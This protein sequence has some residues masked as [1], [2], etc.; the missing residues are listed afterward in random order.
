MPEPYRDLAPGI[1]RQRLLLEGY[2]GVEVDADVVRRFL[3][4]LAAHLDLHTYGDPVVFV[5]A[6]G[7]GRDENAGWDA[8]VP[9]IDS[10]ISGYFWAGPRFFSVVLYTCKHFDP[11]AAEAFTRSVLGGTGDLARL[12]F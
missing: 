9:L 8:F 11:D 12:E 10:G 1:V 5:P 3:L 2:W 6:S 7:M 4:G